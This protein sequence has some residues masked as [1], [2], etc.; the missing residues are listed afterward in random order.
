MIVCR[1]NMSILNLIGFVYFFFIFATSSGIVN[2]RNSPFEANTDHVADNRSTGGTGPLHQTTSSSEEGEGWPVEAAAATDD[3]DATAFP[4]QHQVTQA[5]I[6]CTQC[7]ARDLKRQYRIE[8]IKADI[9]RKLRLSSPP[10]VTGRR[11]P[12][13]PLLNRMIEQLN[14]AEPCNR[15]GAAGSLRSKDGA[16]EWEAREDDQLQTTMRVI[17][18]SKPEGIIEGFDNRNFIYFKLPSPDIQRPSQ[19]LRAVLGI[20]IRSSVTY[21]Q[22]SNTWL[23]IYLLNQPSSAADGG[24]SGILERELIRKKKIALNPSNTGMWHQFDVKIQVQRWIRHPGANHGLIVQ[25][26]S[27][28]GE[29][30][31]VVNPTNDSEDVHRPYLEIETRLLA[32]ERQRRA[33]ALNCDELSTEKHC[34]RYPLVVDFESFNWDWIIVPKRYS[35]YYCS[36]TCPFLYYQQHSHGHLVQQAGGPGMPCCSPTKLSPISMLY[37]DEYMNIVYGRLPG[38]VVDSCGCT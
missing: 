3:D 1:V 35:A 20:Y 24:G 36:G 27:W 2:Q 4:Q 23:L 31:A 38:M 15:E 18:F 11:L 16:G 32:S 19:V 5:T 29:P 30:L 13:L 9:L 12:E 28:E 21:N 34:C 7:T 17:H 26:S 22:N 33:S 10:N 8:S 37:Y 6:N 25:S 14:L